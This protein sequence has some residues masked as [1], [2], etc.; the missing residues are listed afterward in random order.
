MGRQRGERGREREIERA[1][2]RERYIDTERDVQNTCGT[3]TENRI[4][5]ILADAFTR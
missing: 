4:I 3:D 5:Y 1:R 2:G